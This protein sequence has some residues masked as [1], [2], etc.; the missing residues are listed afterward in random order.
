MS[1]SSKPSKTTDPKDS[2]VA[3][4]SKEPQKQALSLEEDD[5]F[6]DFLVEDWKD[7]ETDV[8]NPPGGRLWE[9]SWDDDDTTEDFSTQLRE[10]LKKNPTK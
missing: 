2:P 3:D 5:E 9:E 1:S 10:E 7:S 4:K 6:E 8:Q